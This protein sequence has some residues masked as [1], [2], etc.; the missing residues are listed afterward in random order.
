MRTPK[1]GT[2]RRHESRLATNDQLVAADVK[3]RNVVAVSPET[4]IQDATRLMLD[5]AVPGLPVVDG[6]HVLVGVLGEHDLM[7]RL[8]T[9]R[10]R[11]WHLVVDSE[12]LARDYR[13]ASGNLVG[14]VMTQP[15][16]TVN[17]T[18]PVATVVR[19]FEDESLD[20]VPV[21]VGQRM[22]GALSRPGLVAA[23]APTSA[24]PI[25]RTDADILADMKTHM[26][27]EVWISKPGPT[28][29]TCDGVV[30]LWGLVG[31]EFEKAALVTMARSIPGCRAVEDHLVVGAPIHRYQ[32]MI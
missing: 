29:E 25:E 10:H 21:L 11:P 31:G 20:L 4:S 18:V 3:A 12:R 8:A 24:P 19:L 15:A 1:S 30:R 27:R 6:R 2:T 26:T 23:L 9:R 16:L 17:A 28:V 22:V 5:L 14:D 32:E 7:A 13:K